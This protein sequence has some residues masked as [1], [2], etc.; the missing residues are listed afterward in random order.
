M[1]CRPMIWGICLPL[2]QIRSELI[3]L[4]FYQQLHHQ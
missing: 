2:E 3:L 4:Q 1:W